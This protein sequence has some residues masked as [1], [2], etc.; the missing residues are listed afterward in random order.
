MPSSIQGDL[1]VTKTDGVGSVVAGTSTTYT[2]TATNNGPSQIPAGV[3]L[4][5][6]IPVGT[7]RK[8]IR[9]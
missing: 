9:A 2:I 1:A 7:A 5:D 3:V 6:P 4:S 8:R